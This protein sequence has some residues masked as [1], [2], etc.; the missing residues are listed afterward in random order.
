MPPI[1]C[2]A[3][4]ASSSAVFLCFACV[5]LCFCGFFALCLSVFSCGFELCVRLRLFELCVCLCSPVAFYTVFVCVLLRLFTLCLSVFFCGSLNSVFVC[6]LLR[7]NSVLL[8]LSS[9]QLRLWR[10]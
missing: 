10:L 4:A 8:W 3:C 5:R 1:V 6:V 9:A 7:L 2:L